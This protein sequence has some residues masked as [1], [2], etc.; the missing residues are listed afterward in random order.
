MRG[1]EWPVGIGENKKGGEDR[2][3]GRRTGE[4]GEGDERR[5]RGEG[6]EGCS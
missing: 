6:C 3:E 5:I 1:E 4:R 2:R